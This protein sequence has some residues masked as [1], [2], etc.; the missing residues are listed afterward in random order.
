MAP[1]S[2]ARGAEPREPLPFAPYASFEVWDAP[3]EELALRHQLR[4]L[5][6]DDEC[7]KELEAA[8]ISADL[9]RKHIRDMEGHDR[10]KR[11]AHHGYKRWLDQQGGR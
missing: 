10:Q 11:D 6:A 7:L 5:L 4:Q 3:L 1:G 2:A 9:V 8:G